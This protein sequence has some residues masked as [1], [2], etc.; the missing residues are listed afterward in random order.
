MTGEKICLLGSKR[1]QASPIA[2]IEGKGYQ[3]D[4]VDARLVKSVEKLFVEATPGLL[5]GTYWPKEPI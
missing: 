2:A 1:N 4:K 5:T 3:V